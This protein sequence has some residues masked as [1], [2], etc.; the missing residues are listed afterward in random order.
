MFLRLSHFLHSTRTEALTKL[1]QIMSRHFV[2]A[3]LQSRQKEVL[4]L[5]KKSLKKGGSADESIQATRGISLTFINHGEI[6]AAEQ[7]ELYQ[8][9]MPSLRV[10]ALH[11]E[12]AKVKEQVIA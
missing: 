3:A 11:S 4:E 9:I 6:S 10:C 7:E 8:D 12:N 1:N 2:A 5:L